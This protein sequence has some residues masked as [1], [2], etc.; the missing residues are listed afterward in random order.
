MANLYQTKDSKGPSKE[1]QKKGGRHSHQAQG[2]KSSH[3]KKNDQWSN[4]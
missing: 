2:L 1:A 4:K 3:A